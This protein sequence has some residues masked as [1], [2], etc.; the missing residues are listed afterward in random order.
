MMKFVKKKS[1]PVMKISLK[2]VVLL[3]EHRVLQSVLQRGRHA[4]NSLR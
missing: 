4:P 3:S 1:N 2:N